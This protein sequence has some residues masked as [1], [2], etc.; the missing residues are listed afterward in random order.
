MIHCGR[1]PSI[2]SRPG[3]R[4]SGST[5]S[6]LAPIPAP[7]HVVVASFHSVAEERAARTALESEGIAAE[8]GTDATLGDGWRCLS[9]APA[10]AERALAV[11]RELWPAQEGRVEEA[12]PEQC[13]SCGSG[14]V[15]RVGRFRLFLLAALIL[16]PLGALTNET[17]LFA[18][19][20]AI[21]GALLLF[22]PNRRCPACAERWQAPRR[23][24]QE[25]RAV[26]TPDVPCPRCGSS[27]TF[28]IDRRRL[29]GITL[30]VNLILPPLVVLWPFLPR[31]RC[32]ECGGE[33]R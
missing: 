20:L 5:M 31:R 12:A 8:A 24:V 19:T 11:L 29:K 7:A 23:F 14:E 25:E 28:S 18:L 2:P 16:L 30:L 22:V 6:E 1:R 9:V 33:W 15:R 13:P 10:E 21:V 27:E 3:G 26:E 17:A 4:R 32:G